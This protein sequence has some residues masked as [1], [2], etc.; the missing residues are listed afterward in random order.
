MKQGG[1]G[2]FN[3]MAIGGG[4]GICSTSCLRNLRTIFFIN[5]KIIF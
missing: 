4:S 3:N 1:G 5:L 2:K